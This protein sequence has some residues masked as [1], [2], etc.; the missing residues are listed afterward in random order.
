MADPEG[1]QGIRPPP[2]EKSQK[3]RVSL[4]CW[5]DSPEKSQSYQASI[6]C[7]AI[8]CLSAKRHYRWCFAGG[9]MMAQL[10][11]YLDPLSPH[12]LKKKLSNLD[13]I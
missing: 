3:Y 12:K 13:P 6:Q 10:K 11:R 4:Q 7:W 1:G 8:I 5:S 2:P 9:Q